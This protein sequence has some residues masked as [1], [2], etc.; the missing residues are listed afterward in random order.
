MICDNT[1]LKN[2]KHFL[3]IDMTAVPNICNEM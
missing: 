1:S 3:G 2:E